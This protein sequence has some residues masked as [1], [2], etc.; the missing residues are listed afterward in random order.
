MKDFSEIIKRYTIRYDKKI[1]EASC[2][3]ENQFNIFSYIYFKIENDGRFVT[4]SNNPEQLDFYYSEKYYLHNPYLV[5]PQLLKSGYVFTAQTKDEKY[6]ATVN[7]SLNKFQMDNTFL[8]LEKKES[9]AE[10]FLFATKPSVKQVNYL[11]YLDVLKK[12][13]GFFLRQMSDLLGKM[14]ADGFNLKT[15]KEASFFTRDSTLPLS[16]HDKKM[17][18]FLRKISP[19]SLQEER[20]L[21]LFRMGHTA[22]ATASIMGL[23]P[24][25]VEHYFENMKN[26][27]GCSSKWDLL[28]LL[29]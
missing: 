4:L 1:K 9:Q 16:A 24:R 8:M 18:D 17:F 10:G 22:Q 29:G 15:A 26:K 28:K 2:H 23:S 25:T 11:S 3:L 27:F 7:T 12:F 5:D 14:Q 19:L 6:L 21:E 13:N 20:C